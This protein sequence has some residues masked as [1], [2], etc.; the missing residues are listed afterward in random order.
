MQIERKE[1]PGTVLMSDTV[2]R[3]IH[4]QANRR[5]ADEPTVGLLARIAQRHPRAASKSW[6]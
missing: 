2:S 5:E 4:Q 6:K 1:T 3:G